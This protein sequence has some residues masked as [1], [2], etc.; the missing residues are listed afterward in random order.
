MPANAPLAPPK[1]IGEAT[2]AAV[3]VCG[4]DGGVLADKIEMACAMFRAG[5]GVT[6]SKPNSKVPQFAGWRRAADEAEIRRY[7]TEN[8]AS[9]ALLLTDGFV[10]VDS[11]RGHGDGQDGPGALRDWERANGA[12]PATWT[13]VTGAGG[14]HRY[15]RQRPG[16]AFRNRVGGRAGMVDG[17][18]IRAN[19]G[20]VMTPGSVHPA[21]GRVYAFASGCSPGDMPMADVDGVVA[22]LATWG[23]VTGAAKAA[24]ERSD[25]I[26]VGSRHDAF[27]SMAC[28][29]RARGYGMKAAMAALA[30][31]NE[32][33]CAEPLPAGEIESL[34]RDVW[35]RY[36]AAP[37]P[38]PACGG[39][40]EGGGYSLENRWRAEQADLRN[41]PP[42]PDD[43]I[44]ERLS[45]GGKMIMSAPSKADKSWLAINLAETIAVGGTL[46]GMR[47]ARGRVL[48][49]NL[50]V[51]RSKF[52]R[53]LLAVAE[54]RGYNLDEV[55]ANLDVI[56]MLI[57]LP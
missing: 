51:R 50:E 57:P 26:P 55:A 16:D 56:N 54:A 21:T 5:F 25:S 40:G 37:R 36:D 39:Q 31:E 52:Y 13:V 18:D 45:L 34:V 9:N 47:C 20:L 49:V 33:K 11:D 53:R 42:D 6:F 22:K 14:L 7:L 23:I 30:A 48:Y 10:V 8:P 3:Y 28:S 41:L 12:L 35:G 29:M 43:L 44:S 4:D 27:L 2:P 19:G 1:A 46:L 15:F 24:P 17:N 32:E 38:S